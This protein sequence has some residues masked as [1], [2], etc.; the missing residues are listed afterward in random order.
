MS[1]EMGGPVNDASHELVEIPSSHRNVHS[2]S[3]SAALHVRPS[4]LQLHTAV[5]VTVLVRVNFS[6]TYHRGR[7]WLAARRWHLECIVWRGL[8]PARWLLIQRK[9]KRCARDEERDE[10]ADG[11]SAIA[12]RGENPPA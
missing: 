2:S 3:I 8:A 1:H 11:Q 12:L 4:Y 9:S 6:K 7:L 10:E 5:L